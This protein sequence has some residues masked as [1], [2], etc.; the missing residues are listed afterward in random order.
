MFGLSR[1]S[2]RFSPFTHYTITSCCHSAFLFLVS[3]WNGQIK[4]VSDIRSKLVKQANTKLLLARIT[5]RRDRR[6]HN[7]EEG[8]TQYVVCLSLFDKHTTD[9]QRLC[10]N[11]WKSRKVELVFVRMLCVCTSVAGLIENDYNSTRS[12]R[13]DVWIRGSECVSVSV[14]QFII[15]AVVC[16]ARMW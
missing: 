2:H 12:A 8:P 4:Q 5:S 13:A 10:S 6:E 9:F 15:V 14:G 16:D 7:W 3:P 1:L 11:E